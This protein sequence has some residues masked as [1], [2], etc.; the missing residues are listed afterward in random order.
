MPSAAGSWACRV[1]TSA[2]AADAARADS[3]PSSG[4][5]TTSVKSEDPFVT[6]A[7]RHLV[8]AGGKRFRADAG[9]ARGAVRRSRRPPGSIPGAVVVELTHLATL[10]H[11]DVM[12]EAPVRRGAPSANARWDNTVAILTGDYLF[13]RASDILA[14]LGPEAIRIQARTFYRLVQRPDPGD[15]GPGRG[16]GPDRHYIE[17]LADKTGSLIAT[18]GR[19]GAMLSGAPRAGGRADHRRVRGDRRRLAARRRPARRRRPTRRESARPPARICAR[20]S[21]RCRCCTCSPPTT[22]R[23]RGCASCCSGPVT[24]GAPASRGA[25]PAARQPG[26]GPRP[27]R[28]ARW[29][30]R[31]KAD[32]AELRRSRRGRPCWPCA[33]S[34]WSARAEIP[35]RYAIR[36]GPHPAGVRAAA[37]RRAVGRAAQ[38]PTAAPSGCA[39]APSCRARSPSSQVNTA[40][41]SQT[42]AEPGPAAGRHGLVRDQHAAQELQ[43][44]G[45]VLEQAHRAERD[46]DRGGGEESSGTAVT[47]PAPAS[48]SACPGRVPEG[49]RALPCSSRPR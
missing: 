43:D 29:I 44:R 1:S 11:D 48:S 42:M 33:T 21:A 14:D 16:R 8:H 19:F 41:A 27:R 35:S 15:R 6:E 38:V 47:T 3:P 26:D 25:D 46:P 34:W 9:A 28:A 5:C 4:C 24:G 32:L 12:D 2:L 20:A 45:D 40:R 49:R 13:A 30:D 7:S 22:R 23:T 17:V 10:Y 31:A 37:R 18:S 39:A 36:G